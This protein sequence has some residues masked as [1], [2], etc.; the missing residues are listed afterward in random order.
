[1]NRSFQFHITEETAGQRLDHFLASRFGGLSRIRIARLI[2]QG[3]CLI[4]SATAQ[5]GWRTA[6]GDLIEITVE[7]LGPTAMSPSRIPLE[8]LYEDPHLIV[9]LKPAGMLV[10]PTMGIKTGT[11]ANA[12]TYHFNRDFFDRAEEAT[13]G[14]EHTLTR[15]GII[16]RLD[17]ATSGL[18]VVARTHR[19][20]QVLSRHFHRRLIEKRYLAIVRGV[21]EKDSGSVIAPIGRNEEKRPRWGVIESGREAETRFTVLERKSSFT[22]LELEPVTGRT[23]QLRIHCAHI[24]HPILGDDLYGSGHSVEEQ[25]RIEQGSG[26]AG[27]Q[28][29]N[30][31]QSS[32]SSSPLHLFTFSPLHPFSPAPLPP[33]SPAPPHPYPPAPLLISRLCLHAARLGFHHPATGDWMEFESAMPDEM[34]KV[35]SE[36]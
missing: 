30:E 6:A 15:P 24:G 13:Q 19:A 16:H 7:D 14:Q 11:L 10:H 20:L 25:G 2:A 12:L 9:V 8:I 1:M 3:A 4:N 29:S 17:R 31:T 32:V 36:E 34:K 26:G 35:M 21:M 28:G 33:C 5:S 23:N 22:L 27:E 18:M